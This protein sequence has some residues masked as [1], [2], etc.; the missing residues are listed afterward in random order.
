MTRPRSFRLSEPLLEAL[1]TRA[2][3]R[4]E[5]TNAVAERYLEEGL[6]RD[7]HPL[8]VFREG[9]AG[10]RA[11]LA[12]T[13]LDVS[14]VIETLRESENSL[15]KTAE[16][17]GV[18]AGYVTAAVRYYAAFPAEI[19][20]WRERLRAIAEREEEAWRREQAVLA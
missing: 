6:R 11:T 14:Q 2:R 8:I 13:R 5:S 4:G 20:E 1:Q 18:P 9:P 19:D 10:R 7:D 12:G 17:L 15:D 16:Y 3:E